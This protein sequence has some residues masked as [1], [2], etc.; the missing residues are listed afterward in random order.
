MLL[1]I[2]LSFEIRKSQ[3]H[4]VMKKVSDGCKYAMQEEFSTQIFY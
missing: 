4:R 1:C 2:L 3:G